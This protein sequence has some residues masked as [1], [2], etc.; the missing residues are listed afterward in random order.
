MGKT[1]GIKGNEWG[2]IL[3]SL[4]LIALAN[5]GIGKMVS[6]PTTWSEM[7]KNLSNIL[8]PLVASFLIFGTLSMLFKFKK[9]FFSSYVWTATGLLLL[10]NVITTFTHVTF[11]GDYIGKV[12]IPTGGLITIESMKILLA[13]TLTTLFI[14]K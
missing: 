12:T 13:T 6:L 14:G 2:F 10:F 3:L 8:I 9:G 4:I 5:W 11:L 1:L 7:T